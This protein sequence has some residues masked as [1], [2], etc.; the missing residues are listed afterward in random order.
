MKIYSVKKKQRTIVDIT[1]YFFK[2]LF[3]VALTAKA[4]NDSQYFLN[5]TGQFH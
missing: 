1:L 3:K 4:I 5:I 2:I